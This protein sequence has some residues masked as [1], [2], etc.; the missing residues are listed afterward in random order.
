MEMA[1]IH[2]CFVYYCE[3]VGIRLQTGANVIHF[4]KRGKEL[5]RSRKKASVVEDLDQSLCSGTDEA[6][7]Y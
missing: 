6:F 5:E 7:A 4:A 2:E 1:R 3:I